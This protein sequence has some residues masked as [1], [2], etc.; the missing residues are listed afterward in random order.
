M[1]RT[2]KRI[3]AGRAPFH[4]LDFRASFTPPLSGRPSPLGVNAPLG[5]IRHYS[6]LGR[7]NGVP[8]QVETAACAGR[9]A[10]CSGGCV[11]GRRRGATSTKDSEVGSSRRGREVEVEV[12]VV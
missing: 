7:S 2:T 4:S 11:A 12:E 8:W 9:G 5:L 10:W 6:S 3:R 1:G